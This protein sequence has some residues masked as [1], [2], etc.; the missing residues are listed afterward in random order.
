MHI[1]VEWLT[2]D[3]WNVLHIR[4]LVDV[5][6]GMRVMKDTNAIKDCRNSDVAVS[7][8]DGE[9]PALA[10]L[11]DCGTQAKMERRRAKIVPSHTASSSRA[12]ESPG[13]SFQG[14]HSRW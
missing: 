1:L 11:L 3:S 13:E 9:L 7:S 12:V 6:V 10:K 4:A 2:E 8:K 14:T 5:S